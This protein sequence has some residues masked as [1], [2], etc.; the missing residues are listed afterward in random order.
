M[1]LGDDDLRLFCIIEGE[2][3]V[4]PIDVKGPS[5]RNPKFMVGD[6]KEKI[7]EERK[8]GPLH[9]VDAHSLVLWKV[10]AIGE[11]PRQT[12][13]LTR[14]RSSPKMRILSIPNRNRLCLDVLRLLGNLGKN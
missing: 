4:F 9:G 12:M 13:W 11:S 5:W 14:H 2:T 1:N 6:L 3:E 8:N 10:R 7:Q